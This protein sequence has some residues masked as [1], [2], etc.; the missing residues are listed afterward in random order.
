MRFDGVAARPAGVGDEEDGVREVF[1]GAHGLP[2]DVVAL[3]FG[4]VE[5]PRRVDNLVADAVAV[6]VPDLD[7]RRE[8]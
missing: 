2:L 4:T 6:E 5:Q 3:V 8:G 7:A 1:E